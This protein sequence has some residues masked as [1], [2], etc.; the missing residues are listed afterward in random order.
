MTFFEWPIKSMRNMKDSYDIDLNKKV[1]DGDEEEGHNT[2][3][4]IQL[5]HSHNSHQLSKTRKIEEQKEKRR[6]L[7][8]NYRATQTKK[9]LE[10]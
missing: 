4:A 6:Q 9:G 1:F 7:V 10:E 2:M 8:R 3:G 5:Y